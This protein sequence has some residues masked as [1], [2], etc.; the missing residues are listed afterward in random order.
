MSENHIPAP[1]FSRPQEAEQLK[2]G[3]SEKKLEA[4][5]I[6]CDALRDRLSIDALKQLSAHL[7]L[8][9]RGSGKRLKVNI[10]GH[11]DA[12]IVQTCVVTLDQFETRV[13]SEFDT[14]F[15]ENAVELDDHLDL[16]LNDEDPP[17]PIIDGI[18]D[19]G[20]LVAQCL[21]LEI[22]PHPRKPGRETDSTAVDQA[23]R[24]QSDED[25]TAPNPFAV[26]KNLKFDP[27]E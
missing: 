14:L 10:S 4:N 6:E 5:R 17:E 11:L 27:K 8:R 25:P 24:M 7:Q 23:N 21:S 12:V 18:I 1:E 9:R 15:D 2:H 26:L 3:T 22:D 19:L 13:H 16:E 20:E